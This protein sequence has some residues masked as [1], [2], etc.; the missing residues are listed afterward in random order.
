[1]VAQR[2]S[3][4]AAKAVAT[5]PAPRAS[6]GVGNLKPAQSKR[7]LSFKDKHALGELPKQIARLEAEIAA[8]QKELTDSTLYAR[9]TARFAA[10]MARLS[11]AQA[12]LASLE[13]RWI[14]LEILRSEIEGAS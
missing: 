7:Q 10:V 5:G 2:G 1:M 9:D 4:V 3:G 12:S 8:L 6:G 11:E 13:D 14:E